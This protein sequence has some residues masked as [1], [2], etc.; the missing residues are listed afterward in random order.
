MISVII[1]CNRHCCLVGF[2]P[3]SST[4]AAPYCNGRG[5]NLVRFMVILIRYSLGIEE[6]KNKL[7]GQNFVHTTPCTSKMVVLWSICFFAAIEHAGNLTAK[8]LSNSRT[9]YLR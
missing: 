4:A 2:E 7:V 1:I 9:W 5:S 6:L 3:G 8:A